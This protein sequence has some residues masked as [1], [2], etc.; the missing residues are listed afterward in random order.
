MSQYK[1]FA[2]ELVKYLGKE[3]VKIDE[4][5]KNHTSFKVGGPVDVLLT[6][7]SHEQIREAI[8]LAKKNRI[9]YFVMGNGSNL[10]VRDGGVRGIIIKLCKLDKISVEDEKIVAQGGALLSKV[11]SLAAKNSLTGFEFA[12]G[13]PGS[14]GGAL[15]MNAGAYNGEISQVIESTLVLD[16][17]GNIMRL[18]KEKLELGYRMSSIL[19]HGYTVLE[20]VFKLERGD[21][22]K[23][24]ARIE[25]LGK[26]RR[27]KQPLEYPSAG[28]TFKRP[29]GYFAAKLIEDSGLKG[30]NVGDAEV[31][32][33]HSGFIINR[34]NATA[35]DIL[36]LIEVVQN[37]VKEKFNVDLHTE[38]MI[39]GEE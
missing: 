5:M 32:K 18:S 11:S 2:M 6:P 19:K 20:A 14:V 36:N 22:Q 4:P 30:T 38:V 13:I 8:I 16:S 25:E 21:S 37:T 27:E 17:E 23:I 10:L 39:I 12:S 29:E 15:T 33:K 1:E 31:S 34:G 28:S 9:P 24:Y 26:R 35:K 7:K 3:N